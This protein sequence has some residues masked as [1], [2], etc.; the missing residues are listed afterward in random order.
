MT[1]KAYTRVVSCCMMISFV[2]R[3]IVIVFYVMSVATI[4]N[5]TIA[6]IYTQHYQLADSRVIIAWYI[7]FVL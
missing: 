6:I 1:P 3:W 7:Q 5:T 2:E 4:T